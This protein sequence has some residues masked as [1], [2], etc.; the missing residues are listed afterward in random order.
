MAEERVE[1]PIKIG[2]VIADQRGRQ[3]VAWKD[4]SL[5]RRDKL[6]K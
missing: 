3:Y 6:P 4:G 2:D 1:R 5:R